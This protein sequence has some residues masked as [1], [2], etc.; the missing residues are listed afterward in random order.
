MDLEYKEVRNS[1]IIDYDEEGQLLSMNSYKISNKLTPTKIL[2][3]ENAKNN[4]FLVRT[5]YRSY[6]CKLADPL[7]ETKEPFEVLNQINF[8]GEVYN[9]ISSPFFE[10]KHIYLYGNNELAIIDDNKPSSIVID[11]SYLTQNVP[12]FND[13]H[14]FELMDSSYHPSIFLLSNLRMTTL[15]DIREKE[16][17]LLVNGQQ[18]EEL[19]I[20]Y[21]LKYLEGQFFATSNEQHL[22][23]YDLRYPEKPVYSFLNLCDENPPNVL[24]ISEPYDPFN[25][26]CIGDAEGLVSVLEN[27]D[28]D[29]EITDLSNE[30][31]LYGFSTLKNGSA[32]LF[33]NKIFERLETDRDKYFTQTEKDCYMAHLDAMDLKISNF[34]YL[35]FNKYN[36]PKMLFTSNILDSQFRIRGLKVTHFG[37]D[38]LVQGTDNDNNMIFHIVREN[39]G[40]YKFMPMPSAE[41][42]G[43]KSLD[44]WIHL[45]NKIENKV[46][47]ISSS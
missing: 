43:T 26:D 34:S 7:E 11:I 20:T 15:Y 29:T 22:C 8:P 25:T 5:Y 45:K 14:V 19:K 27:L 31:I 28:I 30:R 13:K 16:M 38:L 40:E 1:G 23:I 10:E 36:H 42:A 18:P 9:C 46:L 4:Q 39:Q 32:L 2:Q 44:M 41:D 17:R 3:V 21:A 6:R 35:K 47:H 24:G 33:P 37:K 12:K